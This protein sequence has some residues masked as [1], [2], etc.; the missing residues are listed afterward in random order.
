M[1]VADRI[2]TMRALV[3]AQWKSPTSR[4]YVPTQQQ[5]VKQKVH[6]MK[7]NLIMPSYGILATTMM[8][9]DESGAAGGA[10]NMSGFFSL[11][12]LANYNTDDIAALTSRLPELGLYVV[13]G[14]Q[15]N[16]KMGN[17]VDGKP[18]LI[19]LGVQAEVLDF[20]PIN[21]D[22]DVTK[23]IGRN[24]SESITLWPNEFEQ[25]IGL[26]KGRYQKAGIPNTGPMGG[27]ESQPPGWIDNAVGAQWV[28]AVSSY[29]DKSGEQRARFDWRS[30]D[31]LK[32]A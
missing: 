1:W 17:A 5:T 18:P 2:S 8:M 4:F 10:E 15:A 28:W 21:K 11:A 3:A 13:V 30:I 9:A 20:R 26:L 27:V 24:I 23:A 12:D 14:K 29:V 19:R 32:T 31:S 6:Y 25:E 7:S 22:Y 16:L